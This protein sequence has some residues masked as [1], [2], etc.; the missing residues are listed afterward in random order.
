MRKYQIL[1][2]SALILGMASVLIA[3]EISTVAPINAPLIGTDRVPMGRPAGTGPYAGSKITMTVDQIN[4]YVQGKT[5]SF[6]VFRT[7]STANGEMS[8]TGKSDDATTVGTPYPTLMMGNSC[9]DSL[10]NGV[11]GCLETE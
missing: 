5:P 9:P 10:P 8:P 3:D 4:A 2:V 11:I 1:V 7:Y 6:I